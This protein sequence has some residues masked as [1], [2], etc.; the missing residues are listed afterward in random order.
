MRTH[1]NHTRKTVNENRT[2]HVAGIPPALPF[3]DRPRAAGNTARNLILSFVRSFL[4]PKKLAFILEKTNK[5]VTLDSSADSVTSPGMLE[6][7][8]SMRP[9]FQCPQKQG[10]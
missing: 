6:D 8:T 2:Q 7:A 4:R 9:G 1:K 5:L 3:P 10:A